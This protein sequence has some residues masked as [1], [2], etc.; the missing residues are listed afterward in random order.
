MRL[1]WNKNWCN[2]ISGG[3]DVMLIV[4]FILQ[5]YIFAKKGKNIINKHLL[6]EGEKRN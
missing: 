6:C 4:F 1:E 3:G 5:C 2:S